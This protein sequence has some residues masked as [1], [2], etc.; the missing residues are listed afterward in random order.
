MYVTW[1]IN[2]FFFNKR[3]GKGNEGYTGC[4]TTPGPT[5]EVD[6]RHKDNEE[7]SHKRVSYPTLVSKL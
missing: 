4:I 2:F 1:K 6:R 3:R 7:N 5:S